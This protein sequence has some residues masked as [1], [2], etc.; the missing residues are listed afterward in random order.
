MFISGADGDQKEGKMYLIISVDTNMPAGCVK[1][2][3][4]K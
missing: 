1:R 2:Q 4:Y 3:P